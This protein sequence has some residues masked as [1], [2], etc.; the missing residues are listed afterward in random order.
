M[1][2]ATKPAISAAAQTARACF[3]RGATLGLEGRLKALA[4]LEEAIKSRKQA[5][6]DA[7]YSD[8]HKSAYEGYM[9]EV[10]L[11]LG[12]IHHARRQ[13]RRWARPRKVRPTLGQFPATARVIP[14]PFGA[15]LIMS[16]WNY[17]FML[18]LV[19]LV[20]ALAAGNTALVKPSAYAP[21][22]AEMV[23]DI[24]A[25]ALE[26]GQAQVILGGREENQALLEEKFD[27]IFFTGSLEVGRLVM[28]KAARHLTPFTLELG[29][30]SP[31]IVDETA[32]IPLA[33]RRILFGKLI[34][35]GQTCVAPD[36]V[37]VH[38]AVKKALAAALQE[39]L[40][41][42]LPDETYVD[43]H[44]PRLVNRKH[45]D[46][47]QGLL[48]GQ[49]LMNSVKADPGTRLMTPVLV[50]EPAPDSPLMTEEIFGPILP[51][52]SVGSLEEAMA[53]VKSRP[54]PLALYLFTSS[55]EA[56]KK[57]LTSLRF[58]GGC[59]NDTVLQVAS[60]N[61]PFG[62]MGESG[63]GRYHGKAGFDTFSCQKSV[64][65]KGRFL[66]LPL[67][68]H[69]YKHPEKTLPDWMMKH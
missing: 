36:Y 5:I 9:T 59:V 26:N 12:E 34:N 13:L 17:P 29:G 15:C 64:L 69:P 23:R 21:R 40:A 31:V 20:S 27:Y 10:G 43:A 57:V 28:E 33:A 56:E 45:Y 6:L 19:P 18:S 14:Q 50:D 65:K 60:S 16:P 47:L 48:S 46:R 42:M 54:H 53:Y 44:F 22:T 67:R 39:E 51:L 61:L 25:A 62:G 24:C 37:L 3:E 32:D 66:D 38:Q 58:G 30:K 52:V 8:L 63:L 35:A 49:A 1:A 4:R 7:L 68:Y 41:R 2:G 11:V 55:R